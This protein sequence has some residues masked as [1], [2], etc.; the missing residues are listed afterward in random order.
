MTA[1]GIDFQM[2]FWFG[3]SISFVILVC[4]QPVTNF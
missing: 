1:F 2:P 4:K 3:R